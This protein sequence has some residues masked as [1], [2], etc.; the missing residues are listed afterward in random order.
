[1][2][3]RISYALGVTCAAALLLGG[4]SSSSTYGKYMT[5]GEYKGLEVSKIKTE[6]TDDDIEQEISYT[7]DDSTEY[8]EVDRAAE[9][10][11]MVNITYS[12]TMDGEDFDGGSGEDVDIQLGAGYLEGDILQDAESQIIGMKAGDTKE[13]DLTIPEDYYFDDTLAGQ[14]I[15][16]TLTVNTVSEVNRPELT[17]EFV[18]SISD[19]DTVDAYK[20][21]L[22]KTLEA[23]AEENNEYMAGSDAL[24]QVVENSTFKG[25]PDDLYNECKDLYDQTNQ[26]YAEMLGL[27]V[28]DLK[29]PR[30]KQKL[31]RAWSM[32]TWSLPVL[33]K[34][35]N[36]LFPMT[37]IRNMLK[38]TWILMG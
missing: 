20:E 34:K 17:D 26:A 6:I 9:D 28:S 35:K 5:L 21:D 25:Y 32:R 10:G 14:S 33:L 36:S 3:K 38:T 18:A 11:D 30:R 7:L 37:N 1:M 13:M 27:D 8:N 31:W 22:K 16:V 19:F 2:K 23:S 12:S 29:A 24:T 15:Q 4:C